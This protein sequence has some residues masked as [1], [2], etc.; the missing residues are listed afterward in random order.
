MLSF[1]Q[2]GGG[3][4]YTLHL[5]EKDRAN[6]KTCYSRQ[7][8]R[9]IGLSL[10]SK[11][12]DSTQQYVGSLPPFLRISREAQSLERIRYTRRLSVG[13]ALS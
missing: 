11:D 8:K 12:Q 2:Q 13:T 5:A 7:G 1:F 9:G 10:S 6:V 3:A 4:L